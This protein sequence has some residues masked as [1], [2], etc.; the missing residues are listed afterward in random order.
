MFLINGDVM[1]FAW[2]A[3]LILGAQRG[4]PRQRRRQGALV[5][6]EDV[7]PQAVVVELPGTPWLDQA[8]VG[9]DLEML[10]DRRLRDREV[11][12]EVPTAAF[13]RM[14]NGLQ[15][16]KPR[17]VREGFR[18]FNDVLRRQHDCRPLITSLY[19]HL[20]KYTYRCL[21]CQGLGYVHTRSSPAWAGRR[22]PR[23]TA[24]RERA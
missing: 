2:P 8:G 9:Q 24:S 16:L 14:G 3:P 20:P 4:R 23:D 6:V 13:L 1:S 19:S 17:G 12:G 18:N 5:R 10:G 21:R 15:N 11:P 7:P 22:D